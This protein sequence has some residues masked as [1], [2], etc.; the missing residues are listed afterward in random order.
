MPIVLTYRRTGKWLTGPETLMFLHNLCTNDVKSLAVG[1]GCEAF[2]TTAKA[3]VMAHVLVGRYQRDGTDVVWLDFAPGLSEKVTQYLNHY[4]IS[5]QVE[6]ADR[7]REL[8]A[9]SARRPHS[10][11][12][13]RKRRRDRFARLVTSIST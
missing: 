12:L 11:R 13:I 1:Y 10:Q 4:L 6:F 9:D 3:K 2:L 7:T 5:E 8:A